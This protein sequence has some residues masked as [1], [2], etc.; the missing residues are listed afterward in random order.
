MNTFRF[1]PIYSYGDCLEM[2]SPL[3]L[4]LKLSYRWCVDPIGISLLP[5]E[6]HE[7]R[8]EPP[9]RYNESHYVQE[10]VTVGLLERNSPSH[11]FA[12]SS[13][14]IAAFRRVER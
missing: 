13:P 3:I 12:L 2:C 11:C 14:I 10:P 6:P 9:I 1:I 4:P 5:P 7:Y 8:G